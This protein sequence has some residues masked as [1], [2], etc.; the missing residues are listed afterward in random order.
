MVNAA[1]RRRARWDSHSVA[2]TSSVAASR[3]G[4]ALWEGRASSWRRGGGSEERIYR[5][6]L[7]KTLIMAEPR[8]HRVKVPVRNVYIVPATRQRHLS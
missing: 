7:P 3:A 6:N 8:T 2:E 5:L 4:E 1:A